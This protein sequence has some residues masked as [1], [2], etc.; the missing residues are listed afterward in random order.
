ML[1][2]TQICLECIYQH[3]SMLCN[4]KVL[5]ATC[6]SNA[7][8]KYTGSLTCVIHFLTK[9]SNLTRVGH[10]TSGTQLNLFTVLQLDVSFG[11][12]LCL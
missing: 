4:L 5:H 2:N 11:F 8:T 3:D 1:N 10:P 12:F 7:H 9:K 6:P